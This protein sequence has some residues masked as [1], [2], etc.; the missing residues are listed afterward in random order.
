MNHLYFTEFRALGCQVTVQLETEADG[1]ALL[2]QLPAQVEA[3]EA[4]LSRF[5]PESELMQVNQQAGAWVATSEILFNNLQAAK[6]AARI[7]DGWFNPL[8]LPAMLANGYDR[9]FEQL[10]PSP[11]AENIPAADWHSLEL[12][13]PTRE[14][15]IPAGSALDLGGIAKGWTAARLADTLA[16]YGPCLVNIGGDM[17]ARGT[18]TAADGWPVSINDPYSDTPLASL[19]LTDTAIVTSGVDFR[20]WKTQDGHTHHHIIDPRTG[21]PVQTDVLTVTVVH[22][23]A[24][25][26][27]AYA[28]A[29][30]LLGAEAGLHW[31][32]HQWHAAGV[33]VRH[34]GA[35]LSTSRFVLLLNER[36]PS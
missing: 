10:A 6:Q 31:L 1:M 26:A 25:T 4:Q 22:P 5:R 23:Q 17:V 11:A 27:E 35:V 36:M 2:G 29:V 30:I 15:R 32:N 9:S 14:I 16:A 21:A 24:T 28:K 18:P 33:V 19:A 12:R 34:D 8:V 3:L 7:T 13:L 20:R